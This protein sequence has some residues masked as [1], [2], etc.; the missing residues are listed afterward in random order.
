MSEFAEFIYDND[1]KDLR[2]NNMT[3]MPW[4]PHSLLIYLQKYV[5]SCTLAVTRS[6]NLR[7][8][9]VQDPIDPRI[10]KEVGTLLPHLIEIIRSCVIGD[11]MGILTCPPP[12]APTLCY[13][14][15]Q[16]PRG[17]LK[18][19]HPQGKGDQ[20]PKIHPKLT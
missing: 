2:D 9:V 19:P 5:Q 3:M 4:L 1:F 17:N 14:P 11:S 13:S 15:P 16:P 12:P 8:I 7:G 10:F 18:T 6:Q 20:D